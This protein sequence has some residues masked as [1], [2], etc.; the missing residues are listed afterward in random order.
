MA[1][2]LSIARDGRREKGDRDMKVW[3]S[4]PQEPAPTQEAIDGENLLAELHRL[5]GGYIEV[6]RTQKLRDKQ[7]IMVVDDEGAVKLKPLNAYASQYYPGDIRGVAV[8]LGE[9]GP[10]LISAP[11]SFQP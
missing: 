5:V 10:H 8:F 3:V 6:V 9:S 7:V 2:S 4:R 1:I 11:D